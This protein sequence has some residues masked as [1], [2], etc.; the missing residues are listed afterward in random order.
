[1]ILNNLMD[2]FATIGPAPGV[3]SDYCKSIHMSGYRKIYVIP[4]PNGFYQIANGHHRIAA[5][6]N[7]NYESIK[8]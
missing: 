4:L 1:M 7:L 8:V 6:R 2:E 3:V 5:L